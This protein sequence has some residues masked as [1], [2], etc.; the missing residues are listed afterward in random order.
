MILFLDFDG[1]LHPHGCRPERQFAALPLVEAVVREFPG[2]EIVISSAWRL[3]YAKT[4]EAV[5]ALRGHFSRDIQHQ[6]VSVTGDALHMD[7]QGMPSG[8]DSYIR[9]AECVAWLQKHRPAFT[10]W[11]AVD[12]R[13]NL[14]RPLCPNLMLLDGQKGFLPAHQEVL[15]VHLRT[16]IQ[17]HGQTRKGGV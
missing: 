10:P 15:R 17:S 13:A 11:L 7:F 2:V 16:H 1:V 8:L 4:Q 12:D 9:H 5:L 14:F 3:D 6:V